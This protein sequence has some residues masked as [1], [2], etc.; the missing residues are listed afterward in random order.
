M[1]FTSDALRLLRFCFSVFLQAFFGGA[2]TVALAGHSWLTAYVACACL[3]HLWWHNVGERIDRHKERWTGT[4]Y[5]HMVALG[6]IT[7]AW[8]WV[9]RFA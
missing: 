1:S 3:N 6:T 4:V 5:A 7:G 8:F 2:V 9:W